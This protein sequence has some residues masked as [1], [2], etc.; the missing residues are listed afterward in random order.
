MINIPEDQKIFKTVEKIL[1]KFHLCDYCLGRLFSKLKKSTCNKD[2]GSF[3]RKKIEFKTIIKPINCE[4]CQGL[5]SEVE[6]F[7]N[8]ILDSLKDYEF[9]TFLIGCKIDEDIIN[10]ENKL[11]A[12]T[13]SEYFES[14]KNE[15]NFYSKKT[16]KLMDI[17]ISDEESKYMYGFYLYSINRTFQSIHN[18]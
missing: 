4:L 2:I 11:I 8:L 13:D 16:S 15:L 10:K 6:F 7:Y 9:D 17:N 18:F 12:E 1:L 5:S 14:I 3:L